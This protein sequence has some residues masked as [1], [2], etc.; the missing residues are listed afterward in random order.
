MPKVLESSVKEKLT[1]WSDMDKM[2]GDRFIEHKH[3]MFG[4]VSCLLLRA[5]SFKPSLDNQLLG[6]LLKF[7]QGSEIKT[8]SGLCLIT[9][10]FNANL[11]GWLAMPLM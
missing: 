1:C 8:N 6:K 5:K 7:I 4:R 11:E 10:L 9:N 2:V 3:Q